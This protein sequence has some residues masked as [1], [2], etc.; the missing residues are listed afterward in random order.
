MSIKFLSFIVYTFD[1]YVSFGCGPGQL[2]RCDVNG[3]CAF[4]K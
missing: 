4:H 1:R 2:K 3:L